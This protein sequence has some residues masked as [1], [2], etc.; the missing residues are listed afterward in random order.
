M[1]QTVEGMID[2]DGKIQWF[3]PLRISEPSRIIVTL[4]QGNNGAES[5]GK[6][7]KVLRTLRENRLPDA[8]RPTVA[9]IEAQITE[10]RESWD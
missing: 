8:A 6:V 5:K 9:E 7:E 10:A 4:L 1:L 3:E 2:V